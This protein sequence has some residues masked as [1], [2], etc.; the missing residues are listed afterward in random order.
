[1]PKVKIVRIFQNQDI[2]PSTVYRTIRNYEY[3]PCI[4][5]PKSGRPR[6][7]TPQQCRRAVRRAKHMVGVSVRKLAR[8][9]RTSGSTIFR[10]LA[11]NR[12]KY[13]K[14]QK[15]PKYTDNQLVRIPRCCRNLRRVH[16]ANDLNI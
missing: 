8:K 11:R 10:I 16:F 9:N 1:M 3:I 4:N 15:C 13:R 5:L 12:Q 14:R 2:S 6:L 7:F